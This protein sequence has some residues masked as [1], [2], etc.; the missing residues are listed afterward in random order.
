MIDENI[1]QEWFTKRD[2]STG[3]RR[4]YRIVAEDYKL[5][6]GKNLS[7]LVDEAEQE[8]EQGLRFRKRSINKYIIGFKA[9]LE[10]KNYAPTTLNTKMKGIFSFYLAFDIRL[11]KIKFPR[12][13]ICLDK[14]Y[15]RPPT[16]ENI[17]QMIDVSNTRDKALI[18]LLAL[19]GMGGQEARNLTIKK[20]LESAS[21]AIGIEL[22]NVNDLFKAEDQVLQKILTL[23]I[24]RQKVKYR[25]QTFIPPEASKA[26]ISYLKERNY[27]NNVN[28]QISNVE[29]PLF[30]TNIGNPMSRTGV[31][32]E[33]KRIG[34]LAGFK[35]DKGSYCF[36]RPHG[37]RKYFI[38]TIIDNTRDHILAD[39]LVGNKI[40][41]IKRAYWIIDPKELK[42]NYIEALPYLSIEG[43]KVKSFKNPEYLELITKIQC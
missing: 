12:G 9:H 16:R 4:G 37:L 21:E 43:C 15:K 2:L 8:E 23:N 6:T 42:K 29:E 17:Q 5:F 25:Y 41:P 18:Y 32:N 24:V 7:E 28:N 20:F 11:P 13:D 34:K 38:T 31:G 30:V 26:I 19:S 3:T 36:W 39:Y 10:E 35:S 1:Y 27:H 40:D 33:I 22:E 14:N